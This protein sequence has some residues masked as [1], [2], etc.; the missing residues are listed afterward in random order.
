M[1]RDAPVPDL[2]LAWSVERP[3][4]ICLWISDQRRTYAELTDD[5]GRIA[6]GFTAHGIGFGDRVAIMC[7]TSMPEVTATLA[8][9]AIGAILVPL[10]IYLKGAPLEHQLRDSGCKAIVTDAAGSAVLAPLVGSLPELELVVRVDGTTAPVLDDCR[11]VSFD[12]LFRYSSAP[13]N[14]A[15]LRPSDIYGILYTSGTTGLPKGCVISHACTEQWSRYTDDLCQ[16][17][18]DDV[19]F[20]AAPQFHIGGITPYLAAIAC[21]VTAVLEPQFSASR[22]LERARETGATIAVGVGWIPQV[23]LKRERGDA[24]RDHRLRAFS[25]VQLSV[26]EQR[27]FTDRFGISLLI[28]QYGQTECYPISYNPFAEQRI[29]RTA[30]VPARELEVQIHNEAGVAVPDGDTGEIVIRPRIPG[31][32]FDGY[33][34]NPA[35]TAEA[36]VGLWYHTGDIGRILDGEIQYVD[37]KKDSMRRRGENVSAFE[38]ERTISV[39]PA[40]AEVAVHGVTIPGEVDQ[41]IKACLVLKPDEAFR[42]EDFAAYL[43]RELPY[44]AVPQLV[45]VLEYLPRN[46]SGRVMKDILR[47]ESMTAATV[48]LFALGLGVAKEDRRSIG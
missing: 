4:T 15:A 24:D 25:T 8:V 1:R 44:F 45:E 26:A 31:V 22:Y 3:D 16:I 6:A 36:F 33:W 2:L 29:S 47:S 43:R 39:Y 14:W 32:M 48:D 21:G 35:G 7:P 46:A 13:Q 37:R 23:L 34:Q 19:I 20:T 5:V 18:D 12:E 41:T 27:E 11:S 28:Q 40:V 42:L 10:N 30:G 17:T 9:S 38:L